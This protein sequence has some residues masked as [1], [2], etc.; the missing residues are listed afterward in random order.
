M[1]YICALLIFINLLYSDAHIFNYHRFD[2]YR[3]KNTNISRNNLIKNFEYLKTHNYEVVPLDKLIAT[4]NNGEKIPSNWVVLT[5]DDG[6]KSFYENGLEIFKRYNY[7]FTLFIYAG[8]V[9]KK[10]K[11]FLTVDMLKEISKFGDIQLHSYSHRNLVK[12]SDEEIKNDFDMATKFFEESLGYK[13]KCLSYPYGDYSKR[14]NNI[15]T[16]NGFNCVLTQNF[17]AVSSQ[18]NNGVIL[19]RASFNN[20]TKQNVILAIEYLDVEWIK[21]TSFPQDGFI[22]DIQATL[23][24]K[25]IN[26]ADLF[27]SGYGW[28]KVDI[29]DGIL[30]FNLNKPIQKGTF[31]MILKAGK[32]ENTNLIIKDEYAK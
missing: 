9:E 29:K 20:E 10:Y 30:N 31:K 17:G 1:R 3:H 11:D 25:N 6:Y 24:D 15:A 27:I 8:A 7:P 19:D 28:H 23:S 18:H 26:K 16:Q 2:D 14:V 21:P 13:P 22:D 12:M 4:I 32:K 5:V